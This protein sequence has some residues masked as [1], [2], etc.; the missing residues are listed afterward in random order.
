MEALYL[1]HGL[2]GI[3]MDPEIEN[4]VRIQGAVNE[5]AKRKAL[6]KKRA[7]LRYEHILALEQ[8][9][10]QDD[11]LV[12]AVIAGFILFCLYARLRV[13][14]ALHFPVEPHIDGDFIELNAEETKSMNCLSQRRMKK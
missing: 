1:G 14:D 13:G 6:A 2:L 4:S 12:L 11:D 7:I 3:H 8:A 5:S 9:L 10:F